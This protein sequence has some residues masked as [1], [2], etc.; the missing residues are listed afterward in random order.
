MLTS[1]QRRHLTVKCCWQT[2]IKQIIFY[3]LQ[4][5]FCLK[6]TKRFVLHNCHGCAPVEWS[7]YS[8]TEGLMYL[9]Y[10]AIFFVNLIG[11][12]FL[13]GYTLLPLFHLGLLG[14]A[15]VNSACQ[16]RSQNGGWPTPHKQAATMPDYYFLLLSSFHMSAQKNHRLFVPL[17]CAEPGHV[18]FFKMA[19][20]T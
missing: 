11:K 8:Q 3:V 13:F 19:M 5:I 12:P 7:E 20:E 15:Q 16:V 14:L 10:E 18:C 17:R 2:Q 9:I 4:I 6:S 1:L